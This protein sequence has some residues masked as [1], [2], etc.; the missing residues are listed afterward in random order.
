MLDT[1]TNNLNS[2][3]PDFSGLKD[4]LYDAGKE[5]HGWAKKKDVRRECMLSQARINNWGRGFNAPL[6]KSASVIL[7][8]AIIGGEGADKWLDAFT[9][10]K[11]IV[12]VVFSIITNGHHEH[13]LKAV[14]DFYGCNRKAIPPVESNFFI[15]TNN[16]SK[17]KQA[18]M[19]AKDLR[20]GVAQWIDKQIASLEFSANNKGIQI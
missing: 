9:A 3:K 1:Q 14:N 8:V 6:S 17:S 16:I 15:A 2:Q 5:L 11:G 13:I 18:L 19:F 7:S 20:P 4:W 10:T 12:Y